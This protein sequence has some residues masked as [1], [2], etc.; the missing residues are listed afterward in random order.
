M[1]RRSN[2][3]VSYIFNLKIN[4]NDSVSIIHKHSNLLA[5]KYIAHHNKTE[6]KDKRGTTPFQE[7]KMLQKKNN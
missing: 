7:R 2:T 6:I 3:A 1:G 4:K 5:K